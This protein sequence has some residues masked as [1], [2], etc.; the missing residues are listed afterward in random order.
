MHPLMLFVIV[1]ALAA[2]ITITHSSYQSVTRSKDD[3]D[4]L[5]L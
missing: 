2:V 1:T 4:L 3:Y 5:I